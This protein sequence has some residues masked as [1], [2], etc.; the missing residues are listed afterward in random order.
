MVSAFWGS[1]SI[2]YAGRWSRMGLLLKKVADPWVNWW[3]SR[4]RMII[5][6][7][8]KATLSKSLGSSHQQIAV[9]VVHWGIR[10]RKAG[11][12]RGG[13]VQLQRGEIFLFAYRFSIPRLI[14]LHG[15][16]AHSSLSK[17]LFGPQPE[18]CSASLLRVRDLRIMMPKRF[19]AFN[20]CRT[21]DMEHHNGWQF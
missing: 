2:L 7:K 16:E 5:L 3:S 20:T 8:S 14:V 18:P 9:R 15:W 12:I 17:G 11:S 13:L 10:I 21:R 4:E 6:R 1:S 19:S